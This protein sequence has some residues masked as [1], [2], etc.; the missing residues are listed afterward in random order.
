MRR[1]I[2]LAEG[3]RYTAMPNPC[4]GCVIVKD[5]RVVAE[6]FHRA[7][8]E[9]HAEALALDAAGDAARGATVYV[10]L[11]PCCVEGRT[12]PCVDA[13]LAAGVR[14][15]V[16][17]TLD[18]NPK[19]NGRGMRALSDAGVE[20]QSEVLPERAAWS[21]RGFF[22]RMKTG[23]PY[24]RIKLASS[25]D[26]RTALASG[27][28]QWISNEASRRDV[29]F[30]RA[31]SGALLTTAKT[32]AADAPRLNV[33]LDAT[34]LGIDAVRQPL[35]V[36]IDSGLRSDPKALVYAPADGRAVVAHAGGVEGGAAAFQEL[37]IRTWGF[38]GGQVPLDDVL[39]RL[40][41]EEINEVQVEA[42]PELC[43][44]LIAQCLYDELL[45]Y[46]AP[47]VLGESGLPLLRVGPLDK[48][49]QRWNLNLKEVKQI[50]DNL[51][52]LFVPGEA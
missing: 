50:G 10:S 7:A 48:M 24:V 40:A 3:G 23:R 39:K 43:G 1:A 47:C 22:K 44:A 18:P 32:V 6:G 26:G 51:R 17:A 15:V 19:V 37:G 16:A 12:P 21:N 52:M 11:E 31:R 34:D 28:S 9:P 4:V 38:Q 46:M 35:R 42:G 13:L 8:G 36:V 20:T 5:G 41:D 45:V 29:Q 2:A 49:H 33:R 25:L 14:R 30:W 27:E